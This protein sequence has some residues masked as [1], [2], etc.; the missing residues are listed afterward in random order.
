MMFRV[1][2]NLRFMREHRWTA[3]RLSDYLDRE[4]D[5]SDRRRV[6]EHVGLCPQCRRM[7]G[8]LRKTVSGLRAL[9]DRPPASPPGDGVSEGVLG[10]LREEG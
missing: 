10:R 8:T 4:L 6:D 1:L 2:S 5:E 7:L 3:R 9:R